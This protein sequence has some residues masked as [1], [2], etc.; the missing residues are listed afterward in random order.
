MARVG[1]VLICVASVGCVPTAGKIPAPAVPVAAAEPARAPWIAPTPAAAARSEGDALYRLQQLADV[2]HAARWFHPDL[3]DRAA[4]WDTA[5]LRH[6]DAVRATTDDAS[7]A[8][9]IS[10]LLREIGDAE[11][12]VVRDTVMNERMAQ[13]VASTFAGALVTPIRRSLRHGIRALGGLIGE[14]ADTGALPGCCATWTMQSGPVLRGTG[15]RDSV[16]VQSIRIGDQT[17]IPAAMF[18]LHQA[19][20]VRF[21]SA[22][23][24]VL[25]SDAAAVHITLGDNAYARV[26]IEELLLADGRAVATR[27]DSVAGAASTVVTASPRGMASRLGV[28]LSES[29]GHTSAEPYPSLAER[30]LAVT[31]LWGTVRA[32]NPYLPMAD[33]SWDDMFARAIGEVEEASSARAYSVAMARF[34]AALDASQASIVVPDHPEFGAREGRVPFQIR[35]VD[36]RAIVSEISDATAAQLNVFRGDEIVA[37]GGEPIDKRLDRLREYVS[38]SNAWSR[39]QL[40]E[41]WLLSGPAGA[42]STFRV[43]PASG[44]ASNVELRYDPREVAEA[45]RVLRDVQTLAN[46][47]VRVRLG[48][49]AQDGATALPDAVATAAAVIVDA[50]GV[51]SA[52][53]LRWLAG[54]L[55]DAD[56]RAYARDD[57]SEIVAP[58]RGALRSPELDP[59]RRFTRTERRTGAVRGELFSGPMAILVDASTRGD[60]ELLV[61]R[62]AAGAGRRVV[63]GSTTAGAVGHTATL[64]L[65]GGVHATYPVSDVRY[66]DGRFIQ[67]LGVAPAILVEPTVAGVRSGRDEV[68][69]AAQ[70]WIAQQLAPP[71]PVRRRE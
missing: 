61:L 46:G 40:L 3:V 35:L 5:Y 57:V 66:P 45:P 47:V 9:A 69:E 11:T 70:R 26:R 49:I 68:L 50:R 19:G 58:P 51:R 16:A 29:Q 67:R 39:E 31:K 71:A 60:G 38:A 22:E 13:P 56:N 7:F 33:E 6:V 62:L 44:G 63:V 8:D 23:T 52:E 36:R 10:A 21:V 14:P 30:L 1:A 48:A 12:R 65:P 42:V 25:H 32:F 24:G 55:L 28:S 18:A 64:S 34:V 20:A 43:Q 37:I 59:A 54:S 27:A 17:V 41:Q 2:W 53:S 15:H 4:A